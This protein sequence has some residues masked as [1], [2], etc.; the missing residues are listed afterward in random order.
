MSCHNNDMGANDSLGITERVREL[1]E[2]KLAEFNARL[3]PGLNPTRMLGVRI[4]LLRKLAKRLWREDLYAVED[5]LAAVP[6]DFQEE[7]ILHVLLLNE[8]RDFDVWLRG[9]TKFLPHLTNWVLTDTVTPVCVKGRG[10]SRI[11]GLERACFRW[12]NDRRVYVQRL[13]VVI[14]LSYFTGEYFNRSHLAK[15]AALAGSQEYYVRIAVAWYFAEVLAKQPEIALP[16][17]RPVS[18]SNEGTPGLPTRT[19]R[20]SIA[21]ALDSRRVSE[22]IKIQLREVRAHLPR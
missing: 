9:I 19:L 7:D 20:P 2:P 12:L 17:F 18:I 10:V 11:P 8:V 14:L 1:A 21:K 16:W 5:F 22:D 13:G 4:P 3:V 6:H 15:V